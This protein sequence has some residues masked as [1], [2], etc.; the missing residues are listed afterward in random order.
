[1]VME[2]LLTKIVKEY[3]NEMKVIEWKRVYG[4]DINASY[5]VRTKEQE[6]FVKCRPS[7]PP[8]FFTSEKIGLEQIRHTKSIPVPKI[9][10]LYED[11]SFG[12][13]ILEWIK[14]KET[15]DT[16]EKL[17]VLLANMHQ[18]TSNC[19]GFS[20]DTY[21]GLIPQQNQW[22]KTWLDYYREC[23]LIPQIKLA[24]DKGFFTP[25][26]RKK[27]YSLVDHLEKWVPA[28]PHAALLHGDLWSGNWIVGQS[29]TPYLIDP[30]ILYGHHEFELAFT[31]LFGGFSK[32]FYDAYKSVQPLSNNYEDRKPIYQLFYLLVHVNLFGESYI[33]SVERIV[34]RYV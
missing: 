26:V 32:T 33:P 20:H 4:G 22:D 18:A 30:S 7:P 23:R 24:L 31:E 21:I 5:Y 8:R 9:F 34:H 12:Y 11:S 17:G 25:S 27:L 13:L 15:N 2:R 10:H 1:M 6:Y 19:F 16:E 14:G 3:F 29:G 28:K